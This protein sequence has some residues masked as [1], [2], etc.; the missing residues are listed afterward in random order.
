MRGK[1]CIILMVMVMAQGIDMAGSELR[2]RGPESLSGHQQV[3][4]LLLDNFNFT[5]QQKLVYS[6]KFERCPAVDNTVTDTEIRSTI[7]LL[8]FPGLDYLI[9]QLNFVVRCETWSSRE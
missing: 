5:V 3:L 9:F 4:N 1:K 2:D 6:T 8:L 7:F